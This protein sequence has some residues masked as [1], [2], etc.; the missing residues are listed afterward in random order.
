[1]SIRRKMEPTMFDI[2]IWLQA[3]V[4][5]R[6]DPYHHGNDSKSQRSPGSG[7]EKNQVVPTSLM[8]TRGFQLQ[9]NQQKSGK[10]VS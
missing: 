10:N 5:A 6:S 9:D 3:R 8:L 2:E 7:S 1:M 4:T